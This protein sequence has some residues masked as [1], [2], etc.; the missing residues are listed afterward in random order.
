MYKSAVHELKNFHCKRVLVGIGVPPLSMF[1]RQ[2]GVTT[3][4][5]SCWGIVGE[6]SH[7]DLRHGSLAKLLLTK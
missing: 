1:N 3:H 2:N 4:W 5:I 6:D 7:L